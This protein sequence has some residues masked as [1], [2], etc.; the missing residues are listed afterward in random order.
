LTLVWDYRTGDVINAETG[1]VVDRI[2]VA[3]PTDGVER[4]VELRE[5]IHCSALTRFRFRVT[6]PI[7]LQL[8]KLGLNRGAASTPIL[9]GNENKLYRAYKLVI[10]YLSQ[11]KVL[12]RSDY[13]LLEKVVRDAAEASKY[14][15]VKEKELVVAATAIVTAA[16]VMGIHVDAVKV[17]KDLGINPN[18]VLHA[19]RKL[20]VKYR[21]SRYGLVISEL[22][23]VASALGEPSISYIAEVLLSKLG[24]LAKPVKSVAAGLTYV[25]AL[26]GGKEG[27]TQERIANAEGISTMTV[28][29]AYQYIVKRLGIRIERTKAFVIQRI[30]LPSGICDELHG[31]LANYVECR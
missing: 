8:R 1:E 26:L 10:G 3:S 9:R 18:E 27:I 17:S 13:D 28:R 30:Y 5:R 31:M 14:C 6:D 16:R 24:T 2:Y 19:L 11:I 23:K 25:A 7:A 12:S 15:R 4:K 21:V 22:R 20:S 29:Q